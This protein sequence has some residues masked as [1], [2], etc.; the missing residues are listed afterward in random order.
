MECLAPVKLRGWV[1][2]TTALSFAI[3]PLQL[4][5]SSAV[6]FLH[7]KQNQGDQSDQRDQGMQKVVCIGRPTER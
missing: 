6:C 2:F 5:T 1:S 4:S 3:Q 7:L